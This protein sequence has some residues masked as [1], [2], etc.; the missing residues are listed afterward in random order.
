MLEVLEKSSENVFVP[1]TVGGGIGGVGKS[2]D[3]TVLSPVE[4]AAVYFRSG[5]DKV[6]I[7]S[8]AVRAA[9]AYYERGERCEGDT[10]IEQISEV[11][12]AQAVVVSIDPR[13]QYAADGEEAP[14]ATAEASRVGPNGE[15]TCW[16]Q[17]TTEGGRKLQPLGA[18]ELARAVEALGAGEIL[19]NCIDEDGQNNGY[20]LALVKQVKD[21]VSI[22]VIASSGAGSPGHFV[23]VFEATNCSA[24]LAAGIFHRGEVAIE[25]VK[26]A[27]ENDGLATR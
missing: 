14:F 11:Y 15:T 20:D 9:L 6:S 12:G 1:L 2:T 22:P 26:A 10:S 16:W 17:C 21:A 4:V 19:L 27:M 5:A 23:E 25:E 7:G 13:R 18:V 8:D 24:A 3:G